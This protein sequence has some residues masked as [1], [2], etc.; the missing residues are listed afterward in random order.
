MWLCGLDPVFCNII[1]FWIKRVA[2]LYATFLFSNLINLCLFMHINCDNII[3]E[4]KERNASSSKVK[5]N[6]KKFKAIEL[7]KS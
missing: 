6:E 5:E 1:I 4:R 3:I 2:I 7:G